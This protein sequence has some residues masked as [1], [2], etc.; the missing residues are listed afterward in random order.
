MLRDGFTPCSAMEQLLVAHVATSYWRLSRL[1]RARHQAAIIERPLLRPSVEPGGY[2]AAP[3]S[4]D[5]V[6]D[7]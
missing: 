7:T 6:D 2:T 1:L 4:P 3:K 5:S